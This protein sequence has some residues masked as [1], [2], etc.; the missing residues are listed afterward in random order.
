[1]TVEYLDAKRIQ[2]QYN[3]FT[4]WDITDSAY[5]SKSFSVS[6]YF[7]ELGGIAFKTD[8]TKMYV[9][10]Y[11]ADT[12]SE[13]TLDTAWDITTATYV[14]QHSFTSTDNGLTGVFFKSDGT[15]IF[16]VG[17]QNDT[18]Y[19]FPLS[20]AW[21]I[22]SVGS[23]TDSHSI[24]S[25]ESDPYQLFF[26]PDGLTM[27]VI[28]AS[29]VNQ[30]TLGSAWDL[31]GTVTHYKTFSVS[32]QD[33][34]MIGL[35]FSSDGTKMFTAGYTNDK[36]YQYTLGTAWDLNGTVTYDSD[37][38][39]TPT[40]SETHPCGI[41]FNSNGGEFF[42]LGTG[43][44]TVYQYHTKRADDKATLVTSF[45]DSLGSS[46]DGTL[47]GSPT[48]GDTSPT[49][50]TGLG[51][52]SFYFDGSDD[53][54]NINGAEPFSTTV[55]SISLWAS[56][57]VSHYGYPIGFGDTNA[58]EYLGISTDSLKFTG[59]MR[60]SAGLRWENQDPASVVD[61]WHHIVLSQDG[62][63][64]KM[65][66]DG[67]EDTSWNDET[68]RS[69]W[70]LSGIDNASIGC[71][72]RNST[73]NTNFFNGNIM[74]VGLWNV[75]LT[76][77]QVQ[78]LYGY[79]GSTAKKADT[80]TTGLRAYYPLSGTTVTNEDT[81]YSNLPE[82]TIF[83]ETDTYSQ[84]WLQDGKWIMTSPKAIS[85]L[86][87]WYD[88]SDVRTITK[89]SG[90]NRVSKV[91]N[92]E[93][94]TARDLLQ[95]TGGDQPLWVSAS[96]NGLDVIDFDDDRW[97]ET[98]SA[99]TE[100]DQPITIFIVLETPAG[101]AGNDKWWYNSHSDVAQN[102]ATYSNEDSADTF[103]VRVDNILDVSFADGAGVWQY[104]TTQFNTTATKLRMNGVEKLSGDVGTDGM[105]GLILGAYADSGNYS[106]IPI[107]E[108]IIYDKLLSDGE[109]KSV[110]DYLKVK[111]GF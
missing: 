100:I 49:P 93:G 73:G 10:D 17:L 29:N 91:E 85:N 47:I 109:I 35:Q 107:A 106:D 2:G 78:S 104:V 79:G 94:T 18:V 13:F 41:F 28:G 60:A 32:S 15:K 74:E 101:D 50:P 110:E 76:E 24:S 59:I 105:S 102:F 55:G 62:T 56:P 6:S 3:V 69:I 70:L 95:S 4:A 58:N 86:Y 64:V 12:V 5:A 38:T 19:E 72:N 90:T 81:P 8:G 16:I 103:A 1:M 39:F 31:S 52:S 45:P 96:R 34:G 80:I 26:K 43:Q 48:S 30:Y 37:A 98:D 20:S 92:K 99:L 67:V 23:L 87:S 82:N 84:W 57:A 42:I 83:N 44:D 53:A 61:T 66:V 25:Q 14:D 21:D 71:L 27:Y 108:F 111:W 36:L 63:A 33:T 68:D 54:I 89:D 75:A 51:T 11:T 40:E 9:S 65:Y 77:A 46:A 97:L 88:M 22:T 7:G